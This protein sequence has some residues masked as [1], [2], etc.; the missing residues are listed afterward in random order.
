M[1]TPNIKSVFKK[2][3]ET[4][5]SLFSDHCFRYGK[6]VADFRSETKRDTYI[7]IGGRVGRIETTLGEV[8]TIGLY[9]K[10]PAHI[11]YILSQRA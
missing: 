9:V 11:E 10:L 2:A 1:R 5:F 4:C 7:A 6:I 3:G 8:S